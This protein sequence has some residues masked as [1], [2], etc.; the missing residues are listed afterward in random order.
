MKDYI[1]VI[2]NQIQHIV[3]EDLSFNLHS[4]IPSNSGMQYIA[5]SEINNKSRYDLD[6]QGENHE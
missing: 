2:V 4:Y 6:Y 1:K 5:L 3:A